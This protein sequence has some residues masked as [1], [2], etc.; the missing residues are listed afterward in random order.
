MQMCILKGGKGILLNRRKK[1]ERKDGEEVQLI[2]TQ[3]ML[4]LNVLVCLIT[5]AERSKAPEPAR[6]NGRSQP[7]AAKTHTH[8]HIYL[9]AVICFNDRGGR[10]QRIRMRTLR[11]PKAVGQTQEIHFPRG[12]IKCIMQQDRQCHSQVAFRKCW[13]DRV[14]DF[15]H[16]E[17]RSKHFV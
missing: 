2:T 13:V 15:W 1:R 4:W 12:D 16:K 10:S 14:G 11:L 8:T 9:V 17:K 7:A 5:Q 3:Q 6:L